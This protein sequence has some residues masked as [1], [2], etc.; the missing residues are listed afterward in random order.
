MD[1]F[2]IALIAGGAWLL[3]RLVRSANPDNPANYGQRAAGGSPRRQALD[4]AGQQR[5]AAVRRVAEEDVTQ[6]GEQLQA[7]PVEAGLPD[8]AQADWKKALDAYES[9]KAAL[10]AAQTPED[11]QW[12]SRALDDGR[13]ALACLRARREGTEPPVRRPPCF[14]D[15]RHGLSA[16]DAA[17]TPEGGATRDV[18]VCA[19]CAARLADGLEPVIRQVDT[20]T[21]R[22]PYYEGGPEY[23]PWARGWYGAQGAYLLNGMLMGTMLGMMLSSPVGFVPAGYDPAVDEAGGD[24]GDGGDSAGDGGD[25]GGDFGGD[26]GG[27][28]AGGGDFGGGDFGGDFGGGDFGGGDFGF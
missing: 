12:V 14:F 5:M 20:P 4:A 10:A 7:E 16:Q 9:A 21:G 25:S 6:L 2:T 13:F 26:G 28:D 24:T 3:W 1:L 19:A 8:E 23:G 17:W 27:Y 22:R 11:L 15:Q 18:P